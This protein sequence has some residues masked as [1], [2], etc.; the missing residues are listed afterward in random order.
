MKVTKITMMVGFFVL[1]FALM[2]PALGAEKDAEKVTQGTLDEAAIER[3]LGKAGEA[4]GE[5]Y[6]LSWPRT[7]LSVTVGDVTVK[8]GL[9]LSNWIAFTSVSGGAAIYGDLVLTENEVSPVIRELEARGIQI[10]AL[11]NHL[12]GEVPRVMFL[13]HWG[14]GDSATLARNF[15]A[16]LSKT[17]TPM[18]EAKK[19]ETPPEEVGFDP[20]QFQTQLGQKG[21]VKHGVLQLSV[22]RPETIKESEVELP[23]S[24]GMGTS[25]NV[26]AAGEG[27]VAATGDFVMTADEVN[28]VVQ[29]LEKHGIKVTALHNHL[30]HGSPNLFFMH[31]WA[32]DTAEKV[33]QGLKT[34]LNA[35]K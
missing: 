3:E 1:P 18:T 11:H 15:K 29:T 35:M 6:K 28:R 24:M 25:I 30:L 31:F 17:K 32:H 2:L 22:A 4:K 27:Q 33:A 26:Q 7:D 13:H 8:P 16:A 12:I 9:G 34:G 21:T 10:T 19:G 20:E 14:Q 5:V 23:P